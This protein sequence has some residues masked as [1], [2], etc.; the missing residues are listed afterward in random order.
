MLWTGRI[1][2]SK[3]TEIMVE[4]F[5]NPDKKYELSIKKVVSKPERV[6]F[7]KKKLSC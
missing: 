4:N 5:R 2:V 3:S 7:F 1:A 6:V